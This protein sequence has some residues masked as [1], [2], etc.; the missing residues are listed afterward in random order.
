[1][2][3]MVLVEGWLVLFNELPSLETPN[4]RLAE[5]ILDNF[6]IQRLGEELAR[7]VLFATILWIPEFPDQ[8]T[9]TKIV[10]RAEDLLAEL[11]PGMP[12]EPHQ[13]LVERLARRQPN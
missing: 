4:W 12:D 5:T 9:T 11:I 3:N 2:Q 8:N 10:G 6:N 7:E 13:D 1:M